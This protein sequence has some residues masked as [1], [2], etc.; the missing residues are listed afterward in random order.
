MNIFC[1]ANGF[2]PDSYAELFAEAN[3]QGVQLTPLTLTP[4]D[5][6]F[7]LYQASRDWNDFTW[8]LIKKIKQL[9]GPLTG[10]GH[11]M[12]GI[13][14]LKAANIHP[15][16]FK[17]LILLDPTILPRRFIWAPYFLPKF[18]LRK[19]H[20]VASK[21]Y[22]RKDTF[23]SKEEAFKNLRGKKLF[24][25]YSDKVL[26]DYVNAA[27]F[28][29]PD[30]K[31]KLRY[32][33]GWEEHCFLSVISSWGLLKNISIPVTIIAGERSDLLTPYMRN[34]IKKVNQNIE[35]TT[36]P[37]GHLFPFEHPEKIDYSVF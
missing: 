21:A 3:K 16:Y 18:L 13:L 35:I 6:P 29:T 1:H 19:V 14:L 28:T 34:R 31:I 24:K 33:K 25:F 7:N 36:S 9:P 10:V 2:P 22:R 12:G 37:G 4:L 30:N 5:T 26:M 27:F 20:P 8:D 32:S 17:K 23:E 15:E 11:S